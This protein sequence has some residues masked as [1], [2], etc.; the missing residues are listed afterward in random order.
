MRISVSVQPVKR[1]TSSLTRVEGRAEPARVDQEG[2]N[3]A[4][5]TAWAIAA[6]SSRARFLGNCLVQG[7]A[8]Q[9][10]LAE[11]SVPGVLYLGV[12]LADG[13]RG[14]QALEAHAWSKC[15]TEFITGEHLDGKYRV[16]T[17]F[18]WS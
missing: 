9:R 16:V 6:V 4:R 7:L 3:V 10:M 18:A 2:Q 15:G 5:L 11:K 13:V 8:A 12:T 17:S 14:R 1:L